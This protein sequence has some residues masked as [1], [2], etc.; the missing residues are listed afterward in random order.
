MPTGPISPA[1][2]KPAT[3]IGATAWMQAAS[4]FGPDIALDLLRV[5]RS[6]IPVNLI[7][8]PNYPE[9]PA[10]MIDTLFGPDEALKI[11]DR[12]QEVIQASN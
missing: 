3:G 1:A 2:K 9:E 4:W 12:I 11:L 6:I 5:N 7:Y 10:I 8:P